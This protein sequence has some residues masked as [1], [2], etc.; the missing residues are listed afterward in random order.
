MEHLL[1]HNSASM[2]TVVE[3]Y[4]I[5]ET[6]ELI[7]DNEKLDQWNKLV[8][9]LGLQGQTSVIKTEKS[10]IPFLW[11]NQSLIKTFEELCPKKDAIGLY[12]K[13]PIPVEALSLVA[14][15]TKETYFD[16]IEVWYN[17]KT[18]DPALIGYKYNKGVGEWEKNWYADKYLLARWS[19]VK[20]SIAELTQRAKN[21]FILRR[22]NEIEASIKRQQRDLEDI[23][24]EANNLFGFTEPGVEVPF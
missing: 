13:T 11:M 8:A 21:L 18:P 20:A 7:Y 2:K 12:S 24:I 1:T 15:S 10:P 9:D 5:E 16:K 14:L 6:K 19:D 17:D 22:K 4:V 3:I 23:N